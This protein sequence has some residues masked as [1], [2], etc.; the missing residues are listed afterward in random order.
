MSTVAVR[1]KSKVALEAS[2][3]AVGFLQK[4]P[5]QVY[6]ALGAISLYYFGVRPIIRDIREG[7][8][9]DPENDEFQSNKGQIFDRPTGD[10]SQASSISSQEIQ[11]IADGQLS[12]MDRPGTSK[13][14]F[15]DLKGL[16]GKDLQRV[17]AAFGKKWYDPVL[18]IQS[19]AAFGWVH[20]ELD[21]FSWYREELDSEELSQMRQIWS[22]SGL[23]FPGITS[24][25]LQ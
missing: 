19:G 9:T 6:Y 24:N 20:D 21:L 18:G 14:I 1:D 15:D 11:S 25:P 2:K 8:N 12:Y 3:K 17:Y 7:F 16:S 13:E 22:K 10:G 4:V 5:K 23:Q